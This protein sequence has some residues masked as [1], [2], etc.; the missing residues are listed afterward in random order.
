MRYVP[1]QAPAVIAAARVTGRKVFAAPIGAY[2]VIYE[3]GTPGVLDAL[4][5]EALYESTTT[6][7]PKPKRVVRNFSRKGPTSGVQGCVLRV[8]AE[9]RLTDPSGPGQAKMMTPQDVS[10]ILANDA[11]FRNSNYNVNSVSPSL[12]QLLQAGLVERTGTG[13]PTFPFRYRITEQGLD[14]ITQRVG[15]ASG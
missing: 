7:P 8:L 5:F 13:G 14:V 2:V 15:G 11:F 4:V 12:S 9:A 6:E 1:K 10:S 3:D